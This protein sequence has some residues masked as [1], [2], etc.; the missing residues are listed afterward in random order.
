VSTYNNGTHPYKK[1]DYR[2]TDTCKDF[3]EE[4]ARKCNECGEPTVVE[5]N[6]RT[7][8][9]TTFELDPYPNQRIK[10][11]HPTDNITKA[12]VVSAIAVEKRDLFERRSG[13]YDP[14]LGSIID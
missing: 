10:H 3:V 13:D 6:L 8:G 11:R 5:Y 1:Y 14:V 2:T 4:Q 7:R 9:I 12:S